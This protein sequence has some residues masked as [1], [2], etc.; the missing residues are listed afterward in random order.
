MLWPTRSKLNISPA[1][2]TQSLREA[3]TLDGGFDD[4]GEQLE[5]FFTVTLPPTT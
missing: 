3:L 1:V 4:R 2:T 5:E